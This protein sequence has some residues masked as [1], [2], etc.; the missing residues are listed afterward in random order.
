M[1][2]SHEHDDHPDF[3]CVLTAKLAPHVPTPG[4]VGLDV[5]G[6]EIESTPEELGLTSEYMRTELHA[7]IYT[8]G[9]VAV[10][11]YEHCYAM[12]MILPGRDCGKV[13]QGTL[14]KEGDW[15]LTEESVELARSFQTR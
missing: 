10:T 7:L 13:F 14:W 5:N 1:S 2:G 3:K 9:T 15:I 4:F 11:L 6:N 12:W 8:D